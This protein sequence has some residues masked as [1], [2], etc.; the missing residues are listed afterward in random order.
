M[1]RACKVSSWV[2]AAAVPACVLAVPAEA[3]WAI[4]GS[5]VVAIVATAIFRFGWRVSA[6][7]VM[8]VVASIAGSAVGLI[9]VGEY[10]RPP[11]TAI[12]P[13]GGTEITA[14]V[15]HDV[16]PSAG[17]VQSVTVGL[18]RV[19]DGRGWIGSG[20][21]RVRLMWRGDG[22]IL[23]ADTGE[24]GVPMK[25][26]L[27]TATIS[28]EDM[29]SGV[30]WC[31][32][33][34]L[35]LAMNRGLPSDLRRHLRRAVESRFVR[36]PP[37]TSGLVMALLLGDRSSLDPELSDTIRRAG[38]AHV[39]ALSGM[40]LGVLAFLLRK[41]TGVVLPRSGAV[42][43]TLVVL[44]GYVWL[45]GW[46]PSLVRA[47][48]LTWVVFFRTLL[49]RR[50]P[51]HIYLAQAVVVV[52]FLA[53]HLIMDLGFQFSVVALMGLFLLSPRISTLLQW[54][55]PRIAATYLGASLAAIIAT[56]PLSAYYFGLI[57]PGGVLFAGILSLLVA[58]IMWMGILFAPVAGVPLV[59]TV[60]MTILDFLVEIFYRV[61]ATGASI[62][63]MVLP[64]PSLFVAL[65]FLAATWTGVLLFRHRSRSILVQRIKI[66][67]ESRLDF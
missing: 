20:T 18:L 24:R 47:L 35:S 33:A 9:R 22:T 61:G 59:G 27:V 23:T 6:T 28:F 60:F 25:G 11:V 41:T 45:T 65:I 44:T 4:L 36:L 30:V 15:R 16:R 38:G 5:I 34:G 55:M 51:G 50:Y 7:G 63:P 49:G 17:D 57:F 46:I 56:A 37:R 1:S 42:I 40:H 8:I 31:D 58:A 62:P 29:P 64:G 26:D 2:T 12:C 3:G 10:S 53:P 48:A 52:A 54:M 43:V 66:Y 21:G 32:E 14:R 39:I 19:N 13:A 67:G